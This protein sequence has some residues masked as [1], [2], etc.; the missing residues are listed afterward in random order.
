M[1]PR[2]EHSTE[3]GPN[4]G[5]GFL[6]AMMFAITACGRSTGVDLAEFQKVFGTNA[7]SQTG[8]GNAQIEVHVNQVIDSLATNGYEEA[9]L[10]LQ[11][12]RQFPGLT[13][14]QLTAVQSALRRVQSEL[15]R[16][17]DR[18]DTAAERSLQRLTQMP[19]R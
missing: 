2:I 3:S 15:A 6:V 5:L 7:K 8:Q 12:L 9:G 19:G 4:L 13:P 11:R 17:A 1:A 16:Q 10:A 14:E 18:G